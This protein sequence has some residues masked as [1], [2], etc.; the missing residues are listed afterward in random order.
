MPRG[1][2]NHCGAVKSSSYSVRFHRKAVNAETPPSLRDTSPITPQSCVTGEDTPL[3]KGITLIL[4]L[5]MN[6]IRILA[7]AN[8]FQIKRIACHIQ[9]ERNLDFYT[10]ASVLQMPHIHSALSRIGH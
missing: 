8:S 1:L 7:D 5:E 9:A 10:Q 3:H 2:P 6:Q 4:R